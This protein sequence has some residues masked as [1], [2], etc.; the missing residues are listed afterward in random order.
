[1]CLRAAERCPGANHKMEV[2]RRNE[3]ERQAVGSFQQKEKKRLGARRSKDERVLRLAT[4][5]NIARSECSRLGTS[6]LY[7]SKAFRMAWRK[8]QA[9]PTSHPSKETETARETAITLSQYLEANNSKC[10]LSGL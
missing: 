2:R 9:A 10:G 6:V 5:T 1:M 8:Q 7:K 4:R 3:D